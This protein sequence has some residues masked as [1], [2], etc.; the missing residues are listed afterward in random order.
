M[1][2]TATGS[3]GDCLPFTATGAGAA[4]AGGCSALFLSRTAIRP[5]QKASVGLFL[6][7]FSQYLI[8]NLSPLT[9][10]CTRFVKLF[11]ICIRS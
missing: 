8:M 9:E 11:D 4:G 5:L 1:G 3:A 10:L 2:A 6:A 7:S